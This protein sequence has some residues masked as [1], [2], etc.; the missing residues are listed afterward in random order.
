MPGGEID[1]EKWAEHWFDVLWPGKPYSAMGR[2]VRP[3]YVVGER[4]AV[5]VTRLTNNT[6]TVAAALTTALNSVFADYGVQ[7][8][9]S[10]WEVYCECEPELLQGSLKGKVTMQQLKRAIQ[11]A[12]EDAQAKHGDLTDQYVYFDVPLCGI[13]PGL[14]LMRPNE[15]AFQAGIRDARGLYESMCGCPIY[16]QMAKYR[17]GNPHVKEDKPNFHLV[18]VQSNTGG[19]VLSDTLTALR[20][21]VPRKSKKITAEELRKYD[22]WWLLMPDYV[23][24]VAGGLASQYEHEVI[25]DY[26]SNQQPWSGFVLMNQTGWLL[27]G[28]RLGDMPLVKFAG[29]G[30]PQET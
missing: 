17:S 6:E 4:I 10:K 13:N 26:L 30:K 7:P 1:S 23:N 24:V 2:N 3:D 8:S 25:Q 29:P 19:A 14:E 12:V 9:K 15:C 28:Q 18:Q 11:Q 5:E 22:E 16:L 21:A 20:S 27:D